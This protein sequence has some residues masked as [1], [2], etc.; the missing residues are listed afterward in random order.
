M[1]PVRRPVLNISF[2][3]FLRA[4]DDDRIQKTANFTYDV[5]QPPHVRVREIALI[6][7]RLDLIDEQSRN[8]HPATRVR[9]SVHTQHL[10]PIA[11]DRAAQLDDRF[12]RIPRF[13]LD[14][15]QSG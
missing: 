1:M 14:R 8:K 15:G 10:S 11:L 13:E 4:Y 7:R 3:T 5:L 2:A 12:G 6:E 9:L